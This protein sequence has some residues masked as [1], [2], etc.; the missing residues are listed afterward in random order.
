[1]SERTGLTLAWSGGKDSARVTPASLLATVTEKY[2][3]LDPP[4]PTLAAAAA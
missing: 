3:R 2:E 4:P 1:M